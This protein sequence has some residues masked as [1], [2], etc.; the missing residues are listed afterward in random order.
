MLLQKDPKSH[1]QHNHLAIH[2]IVSQSDPETRVNILQVQRIQLVDPPKLS[3][4]FVCI[5]CGSGQKSTAQ[6]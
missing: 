6:M 3:P 4:A 2:N 1:S 5:Q